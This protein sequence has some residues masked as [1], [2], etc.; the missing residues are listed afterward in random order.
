MILIWKL[1]AR[2]EH[3][4]AATSLVRGNR[5][6]T[7]PRRTSSTTL[8]GVFLRKPA[9]GRLLVRVRASKI[10][11]D[12]V[13]NTPAIDQDFALVMSG[14]LARPSVGIIL[15]DRASY[16]A[17]GVMQIEVLDAPARRQ[18]TP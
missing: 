9:P 16:T 2:M 17:P 8:E 5:C 15:L 18:Q 13:S 6:R 14:D 11:Q 10:V 4:I 12:A 7:R 3:C 1:S